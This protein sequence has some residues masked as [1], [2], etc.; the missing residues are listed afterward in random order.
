[1]SPLRRLWDELWVQLKGAAMIAR[2]ITW[3]LALLG[4]DHFSITR[5]GYPLYLERWT[6]FGNRFG[7]NRSRKVFLHRFH[8]GDV[9]DENHNH[10]WAFTS[11]ILYGGY[12]EVTPSGTKWYGPGSVLVRPATWQHR[13]VLPEGKECWT[14]VFCG[15]KCQ[16]WGFF[17]QRGFV[18]WRE[19]AA[20]LAA[21]HPGCGEE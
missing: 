9:E 10:P 2:F 1:V 15:I 6:L 5:P 13:V 17:C 12:W 11:I 16:S 3:L 4:R 20:N 7:A 8:R 14:L 21:G 18:P 19:H